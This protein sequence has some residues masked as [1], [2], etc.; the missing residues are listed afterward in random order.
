MS[1]LQ[2]SPVKIGQ[3]GVQPSSYKM[4]SNDDLA[5]VIAAGYLKQGT[6]GQFL[7][8]NDLI[9]VIYDYGKAGATNAELYVSIDTAGVITLSEVVP[10]GGVTVT[11]PITTGH[12][13]KFSGPTSIEDGGVLG[14]A[15]SKAASDNTKSSVSSVSGSTVVGNVLKAADALGTVEDSGFASAKIQDKTN[16]I[17]GVAD[18][19]GSGAGPYTISIPG[20]VIGSPVVATVQNSPTS[21]SVYKAVAGS[22]I[23]QILFSDDPGGGSQVNYIVFLAAQ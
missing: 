10:P 20:A 3:S 5:T 18:V 14:T 15:A 16:I 4:L 23:I 21:V 12:V 7:N 17:A 8:K 2:F 1:I 13:A 22:N 19:G 9:E 11:G 6:G